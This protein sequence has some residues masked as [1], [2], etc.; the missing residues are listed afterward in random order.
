MNCTHG[1][2]DFHPFQAVAEAVNKAQSLCKLDVVLVG[3]VPRD[4]SGLAAL[5]NALREHTALQIF[6]WF[7]CSCRIPPDVT[8]EPMLRVLP[9]CPHLR[10]VFIVANSASSADAIKNLLQL[11]SATYLHLVLGTEHWLAV[12]DEIRQGRCNVRKLNLKRFESSNSEA[13]E[14]IT[15]VASAIQLDRNLEHITLMM[16]NSFTDE[17]GVALAE[18][19]I[20]NQNLR[21][22]TLSFPYQARNTFGIPACEALSATLRVNTRLVMELPPFETDGLNERLLESRN[23]MREYE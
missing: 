5:A 18:A 20:V 15:A 2:R 11:Q 3:T 13:T 9:E 6:A 19:L 22:I 1:S 10:E 14:A 4:P 8:T 23:Q 16:D 17:A 21:K 7:D 12:A